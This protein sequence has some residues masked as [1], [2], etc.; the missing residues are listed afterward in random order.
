MTQT[1]PPTLSD[2]DVITL[3]R[4]LATDLFRAVDTRRALKADT[5]VLQQVI[6]RAVVGSAARD[7][8]RDLSGMEK[9]LLA[10]LMN[11]AS[12]YVAPTAFLLDVAIRALAE[13][14]ESDF[15]GRSFDDFRDGLIEATLGEPAESDPEKA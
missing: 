5:T 15:P 11:F 13:D 6:H 10:A 12:S 3:G 14:E 7:T 8:G 2:E 1:E 9:V 4:E